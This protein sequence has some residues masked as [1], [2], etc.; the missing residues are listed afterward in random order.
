MQQLRCQYKFGW[1]LTNELCWWQWTTFCR[2]IWY[3]WKSHASWIHSSTQRPALNL[4]HA[5]GSREMDAELTPRLFSKATNFYFSI[6][7]LNL[8]IKRK[9][10]F[11][12][13]TKPRR[14]HPQFS[15]IYLYFLLISE[16]CLL[17]SYYTIKLNSNDST[18]DKILF[19]DEW[20][21]E[22]DFFFSS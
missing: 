6:C 3:R 17:V 16:C 20:T 1:Q 14:L 10:E 4:F 18:F 12:R 22:H 21:H 11:P 8:E 9:T 5:I 13:F 7:N 19:F 15:Q 2:W